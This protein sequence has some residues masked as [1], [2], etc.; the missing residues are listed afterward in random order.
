MVLD[1]I[2][3]IVRFIMPFN[4]EKKRNEDQDHITLSKLRLKNEHAQT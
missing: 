2:Q 4:S 3:V 1:T